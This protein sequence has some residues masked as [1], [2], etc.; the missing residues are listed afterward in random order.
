M[1]GRHILSS[2]CSGEGKQALSF[3]VLGVCSSVHRGSRRLT[4][5]PILYPEGRFSYCR[6]PGQD[7]PVW[8]YVLSCPSTQKGRLL[9]LFGIG[10]CRSVV[11]GRLRGGT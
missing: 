8:P 1:N 10:G 4:G 5:P 6:H 2:V 11:K 7:I 3:R 9:R